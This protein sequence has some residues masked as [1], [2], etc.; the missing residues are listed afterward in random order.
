MDITAVKNFKDLNAALRLLFTLVSITD[1]HGRIRT[2]KADL[3]KH[4]GVCERTVKE[5]ISVL[6]RCNILK[7]KYGGVAMLNPDFLF[8]GE[9]DEK[10]AARNDYSAFKSDI[11]A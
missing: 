11:S 10:Q 8:K 2:N 6:C 5:H 7:W 9:P 1:T 3:S 4:T